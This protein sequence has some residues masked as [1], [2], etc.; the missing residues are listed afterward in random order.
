MTHTEINGS[1]ATA[2]QIMHLRSFQGHFSVE[3]IFDDA[4]FDK[5]LVLQGADL[6]LVSRSDVFADRRECLIALALG[7]QQKALAEMQKAEQYRSQAYEAESPKT[8]RPPLL[9]EF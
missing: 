4:R 6:L 5:V 2:A 8:K 9:S 1:Q 3:V 7:A